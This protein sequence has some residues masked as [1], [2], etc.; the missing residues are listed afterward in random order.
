MDKMLMCQ[1]EG[2]RKKMN[3]LAEKEGL[4]HPDV[5]KLSQQI[6]VLHNRINKYYLLSSETQPEAVIKLN[7]NMKIKESKKA[8]HAYTLA[9]SVG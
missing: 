2:L 6:D 9:A 5:L 4:L 8:I 7:R 1:L 3:E